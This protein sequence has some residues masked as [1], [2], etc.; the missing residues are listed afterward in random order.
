MNLDIESEVKCNKM[1]SPCQKYGRG[2]IFRAGNT[3]YLGLG[4][5]GRLLV[6]HFL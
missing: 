1:T 6:L 3:N 2:F 5:V 4:G